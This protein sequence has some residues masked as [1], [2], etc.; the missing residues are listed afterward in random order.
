MA[1]LLFP[2]LF[3]N[4]KGDPTNKI[5]IKEVSETLAIENEKLRIGDIFLFFFFIRNCILLNITN[6]IN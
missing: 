3:P 6:L 2:K 4:G 5:R 1:S